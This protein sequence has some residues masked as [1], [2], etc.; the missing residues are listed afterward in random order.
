MISAMPS[1]LVVYR[2]KGQRQVI[3]SPTIPR[4]G[5]LVRLPGP[6][7]AAVDAVVYGWQKTKLSSSLVPYVILREPTPTEREIMDMEGESIPG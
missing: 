7:Y 6:V 2:L 4:V 5:V 3:W 1:T